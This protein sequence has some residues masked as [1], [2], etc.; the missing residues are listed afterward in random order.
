MKNYPKRVYEYLELLE[1]SEQNPWGFTQFIKFPSEWKNESI[2]ANTEGLV[3]DVV[4]SDKVLKMIGEPIPTNKLPPELVGGDE[5][6]R[7]Y[8]YLNAEGA[9]ALAWYRL[10]TSESKEQTEL[11]AKWSKAKSPAIWRKELG[12]AQTTLSRHVTEGKLVVD[13]ISRKLW[14]I[15][16]DTLRRYIGEK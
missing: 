4:L 13:K 14:R 10:Q 3:A 6:R 12:I 5:L 9:A 11:P 1:E 15:R 2:I 16:L 8:L 7:T